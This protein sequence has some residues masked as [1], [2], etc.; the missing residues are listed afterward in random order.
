MVSFIKENIDVKLAPSNVFQVVSDEDVQAA[1]Q[2]VK[3]CFGRCDA[4]V[5]C[6]GITKAFKLYN[7]AENKMADPES[8][9][10]IIDVSELSLLLLVSLISSCLN[11]FPSRKGISNDHFLICVLNPP[12]KSHINDSQKRCYVLP[13]RSRS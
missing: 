8:I 5:H 3:E 11:V 12:G 6:A 7:A 9:R 13:C 4:V 2:R 1:F 10:E